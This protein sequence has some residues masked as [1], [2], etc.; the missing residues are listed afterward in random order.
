MLGQSVPQ[1]NIEDDLRSLSVQS[2][3]SRRDSRRSNGT[4]RSVA[5][6]RDDT[7]AEEENRRRRRRDADDERVRAA[8]T[9]AMVRDQKIAELV[10]RTK[11]LTA[12]TEE[13]IN[14]MRGTVLIGEIRAEGKR[15]YDSATQ[16]ILELHMVQGVNLQPQIAA[17]SA[18]S[19]SKD[20]IG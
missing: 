6:D 11:F 13:F 4:E 15:L 5:S 1:G 20:D 18:T 12:E 14:A 19:P 8:K 10:S 3:H 17:N 9:A 16:C 2:R 7:D